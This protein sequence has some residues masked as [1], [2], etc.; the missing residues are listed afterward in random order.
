MTHFDPPRPPTR[1]STRRERQVVEIAALVAAGQRSRA[2]GLTLEH[3]AE[4]P[5]DVELLAGVAPTGD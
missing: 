1:A 2:A 4:F 3:L 5:A